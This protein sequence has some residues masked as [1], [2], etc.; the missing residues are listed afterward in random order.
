MNTRDVETA[1]CF[2]CLVV[3]ALV[4]QGCGAPGT[5]IVVQGDVNTG[6]PC[7]VCKSG[8]AQGPAAGDLNNGDFTDFCNSAQCKPH[9]PE[10]AAGAVKESNALVHETDK[11]PS[12]CDVCNRPDAQGHYA[13]GLND[14]DFIVKCTQECPGFKHPGPAEVLAAQQTSTQGTFMLVIPAGAFFLFMVWF[15]VLKR[16]VVKKEHSLAGYGDVED[17]DYVRV[18]D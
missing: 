13:G 5:P 11:S 12:L 9:G 16:F 10:D 8:E 7:S 2:V 4:V 14:D 6:D 17:V 18:T 3:C 1:G 15:L